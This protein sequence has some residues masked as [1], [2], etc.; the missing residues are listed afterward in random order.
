[1]VGLAESEK[2]QICVNALIRVFLLCGGVL[3][4]LINDDGATA[5]LLYSRMRCLSLIFEK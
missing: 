3:Y 2:F 1:M 5:S 4:Y